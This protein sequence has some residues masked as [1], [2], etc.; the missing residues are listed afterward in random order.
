MTEPPVPDF[1]PIEVL[2]DSA[3]DPTELTF[4]PRETETT[5]TEWVSAS[6][7]DVVLLEEMR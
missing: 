3:S 1:D 2:P 6:V 5:T 7:E 4:K